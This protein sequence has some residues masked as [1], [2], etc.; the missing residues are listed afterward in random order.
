[1]ENIGQMRVEIDFDK[2][3][4]VLKDDIPLGEL[5]K[6][7]KELKIEDWKEWKV[8]SGEKEYIYYPIYQWWYPS[9]PWWVNPLQPTTI[10]SLSDSVTTIGTGMTLTN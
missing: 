10:C 6:R 1:M 7:F 8:K 5:V 2:K 4:I 3:E 9:N